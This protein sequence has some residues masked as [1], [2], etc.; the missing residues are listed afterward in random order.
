MGGHKVG[1]IYISDININNQ[2][3]IHYPILTFT[4]TSLFAELWTTVASE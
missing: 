1:I 2:I 3:S 4:I